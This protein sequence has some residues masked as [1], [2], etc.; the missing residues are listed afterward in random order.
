[1]ARCL[2]DSRRGGRVTVAAPVRDGP[3]P[4]SAL[5]AEGRVGGRRAPHAARG[6]DA[7]TAVFHQAA[8]VAR[9]AVGTA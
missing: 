6:M 2:L 5:S 3:Q 7:A 4:D 8:N 9:L 1:M